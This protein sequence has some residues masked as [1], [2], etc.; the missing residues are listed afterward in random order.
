MSEAV[1]IKLN[2]SQQSMLML[3]CYMHEPNGVYTAYIPFGFKSTSEKNI[4]EVVDL[5]KLPEFFKDDII[6]RIKP[7]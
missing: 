2:K 6:N 7:E 5:D 1:K 4:F 3:G